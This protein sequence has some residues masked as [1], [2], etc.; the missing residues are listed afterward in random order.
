MIIPLHSWS[1][2]HAACHQGFPVNREQDAWLKT[3]IFVSLHWVSTPGAGYSVIRAQ[4]NA[5]SW[6]AAPSPPRTGRDLLRALHRHQLLV[7]TSPPRSL[8]VPAVTWLFYLPRNRL[9]W[10]WG[11]I[12][13]MIVL[14]SKIMLP[15]FRDSAWAKAHSKVRLQP[16]NHCHTA[17]AAT[18][19][20]HQVNTQARTFLKRFTP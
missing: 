4:G 8:H 15:N 12:L 7:Q 13:I 17:A 16:L 14:L 18:G 6:E 5:P 2:Q 11:R 3:V 9:K 1:Q 19:H 20:N 10:D